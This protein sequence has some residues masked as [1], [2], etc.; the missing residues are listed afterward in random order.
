[1][2]GAVIRQ[3]SNGDLMVT[4]ELGF[5]T[6]FSLLEQGG[7]FMHDQKELTVDLGEVT[8]TDS[9]GLALMLEWLDRHNAS[10]QKLF[11]R[12]IPESLLEIARVSNLA[13]LLPLAED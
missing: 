5:A 6:A 2:S 1:M 7:K 4:G 11:F 3:N 8:G 12:N 10:K 9:A 13:G